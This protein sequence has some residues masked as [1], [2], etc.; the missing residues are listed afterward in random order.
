MLDTC[1][2]KTLVICLLTLLVSGVCYGQN[3]ELLMGE[4]LVQLGTL[5]MKSKQ[6]LFFT[7]KNNGDQTLFIYEVRTSFGYNVVYFPTQ[8]AVGAMDSIGFTISLKD[9]NGPF[10]KTISLVTNTV[11]VLSVFSLAGRIED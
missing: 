7:F 5:T 1:F 9:L 3:P 10:R 2:M 6:P 11:N 4:S 8:V